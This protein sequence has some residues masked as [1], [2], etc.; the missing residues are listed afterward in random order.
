VALDRDAIIKQAEKLLR[1]GR[2]DGAIAEYVRLVQDQ[3]R[4]WNIVNALGDLYVR[5]GDRDRAVA[6]FT[7]AA[8][9]TLGEG[10]IPKASALYKKAL[11]V[12]PDHE[13]TL[14]RLSEIAARQGM[15]ADARNFLRQLE[16]Q[17]HARG[18]SR[19]VA[20]IVVRVALLDEAD[21]SARL[22][23]ARA[24][25]SLGDAAQAT[26]LFKSAAEELAD[27][28]RQSEAIDALLEAAAIDPSDQELRRLLVR[29][30]LAVGQPERAGGFITREL[31]GSD[32]DLLLA[33]ARV[34]LR[35]GR[36]GE[37][38]QALTRLLTIA[39]RRVPAVLALAAEFTDARDQEK[40]F[41]CTDVVV[42][43]ALLAGDWE[44]AIGALRP[45]V[46]QGTH[47]P[48]LVR[49]LELVVDSGRDDL[50]E[51]A[52]VQLADAYLALGRG[53]EARVIAEDLVIRNPAS[54]LH[55]ERLRRAL[56]LLGVRD[57]DRVIARAR[58]PIPAIG[59]AHEGRGP[60][61]LEG[62]GDELAAHTPVEAPAA[63]D[64]T[65][66]LE[67]LEID[68][69]D[70]LAGLD[71]VVEPQAAASA[72]PI[73]EALPP[74]ELDDIFEEMRT[75]MTAGQQGGD[76]SEPYSH[77]L[78]HLEHGRVADALADLKTA[79]RMPLYRF[80]ASARLGQLHLAR[81]EVAEGIDW[82]ER[83]A[84]A[85][86]PSPDEGWA[87]LYDLANALERIG[88]TARAMA[89]LMEI[90]TDAAG[91]RDV[92]AR[93]EQLSRAGKA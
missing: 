78:Q 81:G 12:Q 68:L 60:I 10:F 83:A 74:R 64:E 72:A 43:D 5:A 48:A 6:Q 82:L 66:V 59:G 17:R 62:A 45:L 35:A 57:P 88:E 61:P 69:D 87:V 21:A 47:V 49:F 84:E 18:D 75:R 14:L 13:H 44:R 73:A 46:V 3:P 80:R 31:A 58:E 37:S 4:D 9:G 56:A 33:L 15:L 52:Q 76:G 34:E 67:V 51:Q 7:A 26:A 63:D 1:Q 36:E 53:A 11:K 2:L 16:R 23:G 70:A 42:D 19:G 8:D 27:A 85:P 30:C 79:A 29:K 22:A 77:A 41:I 28:G 89:V 71:A 39:P 65:I 55:V 50:M 32:P 86:A 40:A 91:Y 92:R 54:A 25:R 20:D 24:A 90:H 93:I 38:R